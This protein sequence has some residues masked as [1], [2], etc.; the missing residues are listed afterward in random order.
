MGFHEVPGCSPGRFFKEAN[1]PPEKSHPHPPKVFLVGF[2]SG[3]N[4]CD[5]T[6]FWEGC[7]TCSK[8][9]LEDTAFLKNLEDAGLV[10]SKEYPYKAH[11]RYMIWYDMIWYDMIWYDMIWYDMIW[12][13]MIWYD[14]IWYDMQYIY[15]FTNMCK[16]KLKWCKFKYLDWMNFSSGKKSSEVGESWLKPLRIWRFNWSQNSRDLFLSH[17]KPC[18]M[19]FYFPWNK[20]GKWLFHSCV[21][22]FKWKIPTCE[23]FLAWTNP[24]PN[25]NESAGFPRVGCYSI[26]TR[27]I[28]LC[29][30]CLVSTSYSPW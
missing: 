9:S 25:P 16:H 22:F 26:E 8:I 27:G 13:D 15:K 24:I 5:L 14:M 19:G 18:F 30:S 3:E 10:R 20:F 28:D 4:C 6:A 11:W 29:I 12:Y 2:V 21:C 17:E 7:E 1:H 23:L